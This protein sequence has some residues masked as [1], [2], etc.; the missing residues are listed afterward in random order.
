MLHMLKT[1]RV[2]RGVTPPRQ[3]LSSNHVH[4]SFMSTCPSCP[5]ALTIRVV[6]AFS[7]I[8]NACNQDRVDDDLRVMRRP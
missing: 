8:F 4:M 2:L 1:P 3:A 7:Y 6:G 5:H